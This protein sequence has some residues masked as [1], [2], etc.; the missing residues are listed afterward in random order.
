[1]LWRRGEMSSLHSR[2]V[3]QS[4]STFSTVLHSLMRRPNYRATPGLL[5]KLSGLPRA[6]I[7]NWLEGRV[8]KPRRWQDLLKVADALRLSDPETETLLEAAD[9]PPLSALRVGET[10]SEEVNVAGGAPPRSS[11]LPTQLTQLIGR[12][13][14]VQEVRDLLSRDDTRLVTLVGTGGVGKT[15]LAISVAEGLYGTFRGGI[16][17]VPLAGVDDSAQ[18]MWKILQAV[19][20][21]ETSA[22]SPLRSLAQALQTGRVLL[23]LDNFEQLLGAAAQVNELLE[24]TL[25]LKILVTSRAALR[26]RGEKDFRVMPLALPDIQH[27]PALEALQEYAAI[28]L[29][30]ER[31]RAYRNDFALTQENAAAVAAICARVDGLPLALE[32]AA[33]RTNVLN[34]EELLRRLDSRLTLLTN[35]TRDTDV[36]QQT[37]CNTIAWSYTL[38][39]MREQQLFRRLAV[40][41]GGIS[42]S[43]AGAIAEV[44]IE[45]NP[46][47][48]NDLFETLASLA[49]QS[50]LSAL[51]SSGNTEPR[52]VMLETIREYALQLLSEHGEVESTRDLHGRYFLTLSESA[53]A[54]FAIQPTIPWMR[55]LELEHDNIRA[56]LHYFI[57][58]SNDVACGARLVAALGRYWFERGLFQ[59]GRQW[60]ESVRRGSPF[61]E[62]AIIAKILLYLAFVANYESDYGAGANAAAQALDAYT[63]TADRMGAAQARNAL[64]IAAMYTGG[65]DEAENFFKEALKTYRELGDERGVAVALHNLGE[66][67]SECHFDFAWAETLYEQSLAIFQRLGHSMNIGSTLG[68]LAELR[69]HCGDLSKARELAQEALQVYRR[70]DN[71]PLIAEEL[72]RLAR[73]ALS[74]GKLDE[75]RSLLRNSVE[76]LKMSFHARHIA[77]CFEAFARLAVAIHCHDRAA[78]L[79]GFSQQVRDTYHLARL[80]A[81]EREHAQCVDTA[82]SALPSES[83]LAESARGRALDVPAAFDETSAV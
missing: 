50:L 34:P 40:L 19:G 71:Q 22:A 8:A 48:A 1:M 74:A 67:A 61:I 65:Y 38:L 37:L 9:R 16:I 31:T 2:R 82:R 45:Q 47:A 56:A 55:M 41:V 20:I 73:Y 26:V 3:D 46:C 11:P 70:L 28:S 59:E 75:A 27:L 36:R 6:T 14:A 35:G 83:Y 63:K 30:V 66:I 64:G 43:A 33:A 25:H 10:Q 7:I 24:G 51:M 76:H 80:P 44:D 81:A 69:A 4:V 23:V 78:R 58:E 57:A 39:S 53:D 29:F 13:D 79:L 12:H 52:F 42:F 32:L 5:S 72:T 77:R 15:H 18:V 68:V 62:P 54:S 49:D 21:R 60:L 17:W